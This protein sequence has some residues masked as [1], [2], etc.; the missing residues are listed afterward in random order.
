[1]FHTNIPTYGRVQYQ[2]VYPGI[3]LVY[4]GNQQQ[5]EYD[6]QVAAGAD[7]GAIRL[8]F[9]GASGLSVDGAGNL[10]V[11]TAAGDL[12][13]H[14]PILY[15]EGSAGRQSVS[16]GYVLDGD[17]EVH[18]QVGAYDATRPL[19]ID[20]ILSYSTYLG[21]DPRHFS[22]GI[23]VDGSGNAY[24]TGNTFSSNFPTTPGALQT[25]LGGIQTAFVS[26]LNATGTALLYST[27][28][29]GSFIDEGDAIAVDGSGNAYVTGK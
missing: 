9:A 17:D 15:Q 13:E 23:A 11:Q 27:F 29:G 4:Y 28:L 26:K 1:Q 25:T 22:E 12:V 19:V 24:V 20:P 3:D 6:F 8:R 2:D 16:G 10:V 18:F 14:A 5:L 21:G 7:A